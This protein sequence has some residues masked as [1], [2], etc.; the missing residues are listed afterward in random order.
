MAGIKIDMKQFKHVKSDDKS[1]TLQHKD[2]HSI[3][4]AHKALSPEN[5]AQLKALAGMSKADQTPEQSTEARDQQKM[6]DGGKP[7]IKPA[8][9]ARPDRGAGEGAIIDKTKEPKKDFG[10][11]IMKADGGEVDEYGYPKKSPTASPT[12]K[13]VNEFKDTG[14][15]VQD[16]SGYDKKADGGAVQRYAEGTEDVEPAP[17]QALAANPTPDVVDT[18]LPAVPPPQELPQTNADFT[19][20]KPSEQDTQ[21]KM[22]V[23]APSKAAEDQSPIAG[24]T[25]GAP[26]DTPQETPKANAPTPAGVPGDLG[27]QYGQIAKEGIKGYDLIA[28]G[29]QAEAKLQQDAADKAVAADQAAG[30]LADTSLAQGQ[31]EL[32]NAIDDYRNGHI[33]PERYWKGDAKGNGGHSKLLAGIGMLIAGFNPAGKPNAAMEYIDNQINRDVDAQKTD[34]AKKGTL[35]N[36]MYQNMR[37]IQD[38]LNTKRALNYGIAAHELDKA[39]AQAILKGGAQ[40]AALVNSTPLKQQ[41]ASL[42]YKT[43]LSQAFQKLAAGQMPGVDSSN[44]D[45]ATG[46]VNR[47]NAVDPEAAKGLAERIVPGVGISMNARPVP[48]A[49][50]NSMMAYKQVGDLMNESLNYSKTTPPDPKTSPLEYAKYYQRGKVLQGQLIGQ[51]KQAQH[52]G[53]Y[54]ESEANYLLGQVGGNP[55]SPLRN[56]SSVPQITQLMGIKQQEYNQLLQTNGIRPSNMSNLGQQQPQR[57]P[58]KSFKPLR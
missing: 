57:S 54:K 39:K 5:Q 55:A 8:T 51:I 18:T 12:P 40:G 23:K 50:R 9:I 38:V 33:D 28:Q 7:V 43:S 27:E 45:I 31:T 13:P 44:T 10:K 35:I 24:D 32:S 37:N 21:T 48:E 26:T 30:K 34:L 41:A 49:A 52:D 15:G 58:I 2:G 46:V 53:V 22:P 14:P 16:T 11:V 42:M 19:L 4:L 36:S 29:Q 56:L 1:T 20:T 3:I 47:L 25:V 6:A 17:P